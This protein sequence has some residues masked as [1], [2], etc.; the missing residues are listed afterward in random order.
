LSN[1]NIGIDP[2][3][4]I[5]VFLDDS[6]PTKGHTIIGQTLLVTDGYLVLILV[7]GM[8]RYF[9]GFTVGKMTGIGWKQELKA[10]IV[11]KQF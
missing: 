8:E 3:H 9:V 2:N 1:D 10:G 6:R 11:R 7:V 4:P 5:V